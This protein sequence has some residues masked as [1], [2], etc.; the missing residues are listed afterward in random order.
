VQAVVPRPRR[1]AVLTPRVLRIQGVRA[2]LMAVAKGHR[3]AADVAGHAAVQLTVAD[4][5]QASDVMV[6]LCLA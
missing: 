4:V 2:A 6:A 5:P 1:A 3:T